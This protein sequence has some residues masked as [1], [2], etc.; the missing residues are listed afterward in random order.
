VPFSCFALP[1]SFWTEPRALG[2][3]FIFCAPGFFSAVPRATGPVFKFCAFGLVFGSAECVGCHFH[4]LCFRT[5]FRWCR[6]RLVPFSCF[7]R[8]VLIFDGTEAVRSRFHVLCARTNFRWYRGRR[9]SFS[10]FV[11]PD[12]ISAVP[13]ATGPVFMLCAPALVFGGTEGFWCRFHVLPARTHF[14]R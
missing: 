14:W 9:L 8:S 12:S 4:V 13:R 2:P 10:C 7:A 3:V 5:H 6:V 1:E 11:L